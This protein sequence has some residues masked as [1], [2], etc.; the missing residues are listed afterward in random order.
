M[1]ILTVMMTIRPGP[2]S[3]GDENLFLNID[4]VSVEVAD[5]GCGRRSHADRRRLLWRWFD[6]CAGLGMV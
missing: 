6:S 5:G 4:D 1:M 2:T 3:S